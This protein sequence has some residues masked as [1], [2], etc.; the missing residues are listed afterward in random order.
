MVLTESESL[1]VTT[2]G[3]K[4][5]AV[6][7]ILRFILKMQIHLSLC[8]PVMFYFILD[9]LQEAKKLLGKMKYF[10][11]LEDKLKAKKIPS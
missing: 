8:K 6:T 4:T 7:E 5:G 3:T 11:N 1:Q 10:A 9:D 2:L